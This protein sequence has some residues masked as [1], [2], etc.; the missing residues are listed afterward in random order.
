MTVYDIDL[1]EAS[2]LS[3][4]RTDAT[5]GG[6]STVL[7]AELVYLDAL[8]TSA[9]HSAR[10]FRSDPDDR[11]WWLPRFQEVMNAKFNTDLTQTECHTIAITVNKL[12][13]QLKK[14]ILHIAKLLAS[15]ESTPSNSQPPNSKDSTST[16]P[17][18]K[19]AEISMPGWETAP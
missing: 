16:S 18:P 17:E 7:S 5:T 6:K 10:R 15:M 14:N 9:Q 8:L 12:G 13:E 11:L 4:S 3:F 2:Q 19:P 1:P